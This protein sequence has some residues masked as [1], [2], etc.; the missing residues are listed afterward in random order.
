M[1]AVYFGERQTQ[2]LTQSYRIEKA[3]GGIEIINGLRG[4]FNL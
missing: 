3:V 2:E 1:T 4:L